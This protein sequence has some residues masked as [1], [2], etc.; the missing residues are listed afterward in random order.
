MRKKTGRQKARTQTDRIRQV[1]YMIKPFQR[2]PPD[3]WPA[4]PL[5]FAIFVVFFGLITLLLELFKRS[6]FVNQIF[7]DPSRQRNEVNSSVHFSL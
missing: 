3:A 4:D 1:S 5:E 7:G 2:H 6:P